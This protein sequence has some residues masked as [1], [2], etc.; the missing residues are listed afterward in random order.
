MTGDLCDMHR[1]PSRTIEQPLWLLQ[2]EAMQMTETAKPM[3]PI[4][5]T[6]DKTKPKTSARPAGATL[7]AKLPPNPVAGLMFDPMDL[8]GVSLA[9]TFAGHTMSVA[10]MCLHPT[11][12]I[13]VTA[14]D[15]KTWKMWHL[16]AGD[17]IMC[18]EGHKGWVSG[19]DFH[20]KVK[21]GGPQSAAHRSP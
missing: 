12:P 16:P 9:R 1:R 6:T 14:S 13:V 5:K 21:S 15:D 20:P 8:N 7:P 18:G 19:V 2:V 17:L 10:N 4:P 11:K 3:D